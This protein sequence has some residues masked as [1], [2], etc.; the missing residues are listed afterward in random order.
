MTQSTFDSK[1]RPRPWSAVEPSPEERERRAEMDRVARAR[2]DQ[3]LRAQELD[4]QEHGDDCEPCD[5]NA[6]ELKA[7]AVPNRSD[8]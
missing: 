7:D 2:V 4:E 6:G 5:A 3:E 1:I 8:R